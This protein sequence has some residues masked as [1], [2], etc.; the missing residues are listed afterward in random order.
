MIC[1]VE[2]PDRENHRSKTNLL[3][4]VVENIAP[5]GFDGRRT[6]CFVAAHLPNSLSPQKLEDV[7]LIPFVASNARQFSCIRMYSTEPWVGDTIITMLIN[8][9]FCMRLHS[10]ESAR[11][12]ELLSDIQ[13]RRPERVH[14]G[15]SPATSFAFLQEAMSTPP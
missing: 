11:F 7:L 10:F 9:Q 3:D 4:D 13:K 5:R 12:R 14:R 15:S 8:A 1:F 6:H 2:R